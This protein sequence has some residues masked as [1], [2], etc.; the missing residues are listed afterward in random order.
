[1]SSIPRQEICVKY[2]VRHGLILGITIGRTEPVLFKSYLLILEIHSKNAALNF[3]N[4]EKNMNFKAIIQL[5]D[6]HFWRSENSIA[7]KERA[8][9]K[10]GNNN[11]A[12]YG[13]VLEAK[14]TNIA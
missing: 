12:A 5:K 2:W 1:M 6:L 7:I 3:M 11:A 9:L 14:F 8:V 10:N 4:H 13:I